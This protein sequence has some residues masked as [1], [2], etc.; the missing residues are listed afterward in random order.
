MFGNFLVKEREYVKY[1]GQMLYGNGLEESAF[2]TPKERV[3]RI[4]GATMEVKSVIEQFEM[5]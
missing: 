3:G 4:E 1:L 2:A 5:Q